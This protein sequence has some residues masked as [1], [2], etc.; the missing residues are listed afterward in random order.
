MKIFLILA[1]FALCPMPK[2]YILY[3][4]VYKDYYCSDGKYRFEKFKAARLDYNDAVKMRIKLWHRS[5]YADPEPIFIE[6][7]SQR[8][9]TPNPWSETP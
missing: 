5:E 4:V 3:D 1:L 6:H 9:P 2:E 8:K 7:V